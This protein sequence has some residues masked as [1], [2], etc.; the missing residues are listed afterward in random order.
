MKRTEPRTIVSWARNGFWFSLSLALSHYRA[1]LQFFLHFCGS[2]HETVKGF[3]STALIICKMITLTNRYR[4]NSSACVFFAFAYFL[5]CLNLSLA[6]N[7]G[8]RVTQ[9]YNKLISAWPLNWY[10]L[11]SLN[12]AIEMLIDLCVSE[13]IIIWR[14]SDQVM[15]E[16]GDRHLT[17][18]QPC[19]PSHNRGDRFNGFR[20]SILN[21]IQICVNWKW[22]LKKL[23][24]S[25]S[26]EPLKEKFMNESNGG[27]PKGEQNSTR[28]CSA[29]LAPNRNTYRA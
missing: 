6:W 23:W 21:A 7:K 19:Q 1:S 8:F 28:K 20:I 12:R 25:C 15:N 16:S 17:Q 9:N 13:A 18:Q 3:S 4:R 5:F 2:L 11:S 24:I 26:K 27:R 14:P 10:R 22:K 29:S